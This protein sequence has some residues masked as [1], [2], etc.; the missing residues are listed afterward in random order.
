MRARLKNSSKVFCFH[1]HVQLWMIFSSVIRSQTARVHVTLFRHYFLTLRSGTFMCHW[2]GP[3]G[4]CWM[5][6]W[7]SRLLHSGMTSSGGCWDGLGWWHWPWLQR[8]L[9][10]KRAYISQHHRSNL[11]PSSGCKGASPDPVGKRYIAY[12]RMEVP[13]CNGSGDEHF[14][15]DDSQ[16]GGIRGR[17]RWSGSVVVQNPRRSMVYSGIDGNSIF[18]SSADVCSQKEGDFWIE[19]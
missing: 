17:G 15:S 5:S 13:L 3:D 18:S 10:L 14:G 19:D 2:G 6:G 7:S 1:R 4:G 8:W 16:Y 9:V 12:H 11:L